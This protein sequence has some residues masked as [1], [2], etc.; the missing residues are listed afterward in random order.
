MKVLVSDKLSDRGVEILKNAGLTVDVK[1]GLKPDELRSIIGDYEAL[2][3][4]SATKATADI[5]NAGTNLKVIGR[6]GS[7]LDNVDKTAATQRGIVV[8][9]TPG[10]NTITTAEHAITMMLS[11]ARMIPQ[12]T[13]SMK[14]GQWEKKKFLGVEIYNKVLGILGIGNI[15]SQVAKRAQALGMHVLA[16]DP[17][18]S[19]DAAKTLAINLTSLE[20]VL[21]QSDFITIHTSL[22]EESKNM[23]NKERIAM[24]K[25]GVRIINCA[26]GGIVNEADLCEALKSGKIAA[27]ALD[28]FEKEPPV[29]SPLLG[30]DNVICTPHLGASTNEAQENVAIAVAEQIVDYLTKGIIRNAA[31][32]P[33]VSPEMLSTLAPYLQ[34]GERMGSFLSQLINGPIQKIIIEYRGQVAELPREPIT[35]AVIRGALA[36][37]LNESVNY[38]NAPLIAKER[39][40][41]VK[42]TTTANAGDYLSM[43]E[44]KLFANGDVHQMA[45][46]LHGKREPRIVVIENFAIEVVPEG[47]MLV[48]ANIDTPGVI[49]NIGSLLGSRGFNISRMQW[50]REKRGGKAISVVSIEPAGT[51]EILNEMKLLPNVLS[52]QRVNLP[53]LPS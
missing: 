22:T 35:Y 53:P 47:E 2:I 42:E 37:I 25:D 36:P 24:M 33:S 18:L 8:M 27:C 49:G 17:F 34:L 50:G 29:G 1:T 20:E 23:I 44:L 5:I 31:N 48:V 13:A 43:I 38:V 30:M 19:K 9:N 12:A 7:G 45:G 15:G 40:I 4:R 26:R 6:A 28:V 46:V 10:G 52:I 32:Y 16:Y 14:A 51:S 11:M 41:E 39:G 3:V 21:K